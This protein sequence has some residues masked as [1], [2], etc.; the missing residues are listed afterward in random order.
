MKVAYLS[1]MSH[2]GLLLSTQIF[3]KNHTLMKYIGSFSTQKTH[4][5]VLSMRAIDFPHN[6]PLERSFP[7][8]KA[9]QFFEKR[10]C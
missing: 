8:K 9:K 3:S 7:K 4:F 10:S 6:L 2:L 5:H 1:A